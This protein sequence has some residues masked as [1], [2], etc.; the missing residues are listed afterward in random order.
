MEV[1]QQDNGLRVF[2]MTF[3]ASLT[4]TQIRLTGTEFNRSLL[5]LTSVWLDK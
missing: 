5:L 2:R 4:F 1:Y 3:H